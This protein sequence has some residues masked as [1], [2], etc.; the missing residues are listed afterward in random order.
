MRKIDM[1]HGPLA[2]SLFYFA[3]P[4]VIT[5]ILQQLFNTADVAVIGTFVGKEAMAGVGTCSPIVG[6]IVSLCE[7]LSL[8]RRLSSRRLLVRKIKRGSLM[9]SIVRSCFH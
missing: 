5:G 1:T 3:L 4:I 8:G 6:I 9:E 7:G 2:S